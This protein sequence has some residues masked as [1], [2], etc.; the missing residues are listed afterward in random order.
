M[1]VRALTLPIGQTIL[2]NTLS[3]EV[4]RHHLEISPQS[5]IHAGATNLK[6]LTTDGT[7]LLALQACYSQAVTNVLYFALAAIALG[8]P[9]AICMEWKTLKGPQTKEKDGGEHSELEK[10]AEAT[11]S[12]EA[13]KS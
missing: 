7:V 5:V 1:S 2:V 9:F 3:S 8:M 6:S 4:S 13:T 11:T 12:T 10:L